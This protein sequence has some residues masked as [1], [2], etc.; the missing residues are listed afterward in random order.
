MMKKYEQVKM[1]IKKLIE[2]GDYIPDQR[3][4][5]EYSLTQQFGVS[6]HTVRKAIN[7]LVNEGW[8][9]TEQGSGTFCA[10]RNTN[11]PSEKTIALLTTYISNY[12]FP[13]IINGVESYLSSKGYT[14]L[15]YSTNNDLNKEK[16]CL[17]NIS[18]RGIAGLIVEPTKSNYY[19][20]NLKYYLNLERKKIPYLMINAYYPE[21]H[22]YRL[23]V[24]DE[25]GAYMATEHLIKLGHGRIAGIFKTDDQQGVKRM[26][27]FI[28]AH[29]EYSIPILPN[30][31]LP[32]TTIE[33]DKVLNEEFMGLLNSEQRPT[34]LFCYN[35]EIAL[36]ALDVIREYGISVPDDLSIVGF[37]DSNLATASEVKLTTIRHPQFEMGRQAAET[38]IQL[39]E[40]KVDGD[41][42][43]RYKPEL[44]LRNSTRKL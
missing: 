2:E 5:S 7:D 24:D 32:C 36:S 25:L 10:D 14:L 1:E 11:Q 15:L 30:M 9:Y 20:P 19:N 3:I 28:K 18:N 27:G 22:P 26:Q 44:I 41:P 31:I 4:S 13:S 34:G 40:N 38:I 12:I 23:T 16:L 17:E 6:R 8:L 39:I 21:L 33:K 42:S 43:I 29:R 37:D 35:D